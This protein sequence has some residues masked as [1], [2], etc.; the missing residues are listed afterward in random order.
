MWIKLGE[1]VEVGR[2][3]I[4]WLETTSA[5]VDF[6]IYNLHWTSFLG[7]IAWSK[8]RITGSFSF[9]CTMSILLH[10]L[11]SFFQPGLFPSPHTHTQ[12]HTQA[13]SS[14]VASRNTFLGWVLNLGFVI[15][16]RFIVSKNLGG[17]C[18]ERLYCIHYFTEVKAYNILSFMRLCHIPQM[19]P[20]N[21]HFSE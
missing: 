15:C 10:S 6:G 13:D 19:S 18:F 8:K 5:E 1:W 21:L 12:T 3:K 4:K 7:P 20:I 9:W 2:Y 14:S 11:P 17:W 16:E